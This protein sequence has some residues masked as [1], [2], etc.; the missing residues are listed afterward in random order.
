MAAPSDS[1]LS[2]QIAELQKEVA[3][4]RRR[5]VAL[6]RLIGAASEHATDRTVVQG[7]VSY[8]WQS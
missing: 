5:L 7:K 6:E 8:D 4:L 1:D 2:T 3:D